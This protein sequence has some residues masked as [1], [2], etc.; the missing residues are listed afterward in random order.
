MDVYVDLCGLSM[1]NYVDHY[2]DLYRLLPD[3]NGAIC[4]MLQISM[5]IVAD[6]YVEYN[7]LPGKQ[8]C[9]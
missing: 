4:R 8:S 7:S 6:Q 1:W 9:F 3:V 2:V 5:W